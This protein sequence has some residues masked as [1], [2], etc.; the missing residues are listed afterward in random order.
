MAAMPRPSGKAEKIA[1][2]ILGKPATDTPR[3]KYMKELDSQYTYSYG[4]YSR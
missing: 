4:R 2:K 3:S 1:R